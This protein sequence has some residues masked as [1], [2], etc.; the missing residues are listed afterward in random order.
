MLGATVYTFSIIL[1]VFLAGLG[2]GSM[3]GSLLAR[4]RARPEIALGWCQVLLAAAMAWAAWMLTCSLPYWPVNPG[5]PAT[6]PWFTFQLDL[7]RC[8]WAL[9]PATV[10]WGA[11]FPLAL[12]AVAARGLD[13]G[14]LVGKVYAANTVGAIIGRA[15]NQPSLDCVAGHARHSAPAHRPLRRLRPGSPLCRF[16]AAARRGGFR[17]IRRLAGLPSHG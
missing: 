17:P 3:A 16:L 10:L 5:L 9:L 1:A 14:R 12:A 7:V 6:S 8:L 2:L 4:S 15:G 11:S 13:P